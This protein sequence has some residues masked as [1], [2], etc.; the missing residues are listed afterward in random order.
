MLGI[1]LLFHVWKRFS[2]LA[3]N[4]GKS[5]NNGWYGILAYVLGILTFGF[6]LGILN[7]IFS[8]GID[9]D[10]NFSINL[11]EIPVGI[12][13]CYILYK[14]LE[15]KWQSQYVEIETINDIGKTID[16]E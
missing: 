3:L 14:I 11:I 12:L 1:I 10:N 6:A 7:E 2:E 13:C 16:V 4:F 5:K 9:W 8:W 15:R